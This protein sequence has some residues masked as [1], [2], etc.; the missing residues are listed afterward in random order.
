MPATGLTDPP[1]RE[2]ASRVSSG[3][4][5]T[6]FWNQRTGAVTVSVW[7]RDSGQHLQFAVPPAKALDAFYHPYAYA[8]PVVGA[9]TARRSQ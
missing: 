4:E 3:A 6:L 8:T 9:R 7:N 5:T 2:L 1:P